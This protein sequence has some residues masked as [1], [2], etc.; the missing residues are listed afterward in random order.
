[1]TENR[2]WRVIQ[3]SQKIEL[4]T[5]RLVFIWAVG[6]W[7]I[8]ASPF[9]LSDMLD[10]ETQE[11]IVSIAAPFFP[12]EG[13]LDD[14]ESAVVVEITDETLYA[15]RVNQCLEACTRVC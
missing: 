6:L 2:I 14:D 8:H 12:P 5:F 9:H 11:I 3:K 1:M 10:A 7:L 13:R 15:L 4:F